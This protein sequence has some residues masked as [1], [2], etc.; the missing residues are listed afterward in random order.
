MR[1]TGVKISDDY[2]KG[3]TLALVEWA[4]AIV[5]V[6]EQYG[7]E[8]VDR[9]PESFLDLGVVCWHGSPCLRNRMVAERL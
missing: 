6:E 1:E 9:V 8:I 2:P 3:L 4:D 5:P 7:E